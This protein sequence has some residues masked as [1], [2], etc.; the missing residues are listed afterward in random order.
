MIE[1]T[2]IRRILLGH[3]TMPA[4]SSM[5]GQKIVVCAYVIR[6]PDGTVLFDTGLGRH[7]EAERIYHPVARDVLAE[8]PRA[9]TPVDNV[10]AVVNCHLHVDHAGGNPHVPGRPIF[11]QR[12][13]VDA[14]GDWEYTNPNV[15]DF[16]G[17]WLEIHDGEAGVAPGLRIIPTPGHTPGHQSLVVE[18]RKGRVVLAGQAFSGAS[19]YGRAAFASHVAARGEP[20]D[21]DVPT[22]VRTIQ[23]EIDPVRILFAHDLAVWERTG[24]LAPPR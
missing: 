3:F 9:G 10:R 18:T 15:V 16:E 5:P 21:V 11:A 20:V 6:H 12:A 1:L 19:D 14:A 2:D 22:C 7:E 8:L 4:D 13:E 24:V 17:V 23:E